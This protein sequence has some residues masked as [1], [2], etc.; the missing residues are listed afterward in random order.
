MT[1]E[2]TDEAKE[3]EEAQAGFAAGYERA[4]G[5][6]APAAPAAP[7]KSDAEKEA[8]AQAEAK[9]LAE[10]EWDGVPNVVR[11][12]LEELGSLPNTVNKLAGHIGGL[13]NATSRI[14]ATLKAAKAATQEA[15]GKAPS[16][17][18][19]KAAISNPA[20]W[21][22]L[23][24]EWDWPEEWSSTIESE[25][26]ALR[27]EIGKKGSVDVESVQKEILSRVGDR[28]GSFSTDLREVIRVDM[29]HPG[30][31]DTVKKDGFVSWSLDGGP[32]KEQYAQ[33][34]EIQETDPA[35]ANE[36]IHGFARNHPEWWALKGAA[37][38]SNRASDAIHLLDGYSEHQKQVTAEDAAR[39]KR[40][41][42][43][44]GAVVPKGTGGPAHT[45]ISDAEAFAR[46]YKRAK[47]LK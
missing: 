18:Q 47:G 38:F 17:E 14:E 5:T 27:E 21:K 15:G 20:A 4:K 3:L 2:L 6:K 10:K 9:A 25:F 16:D 40:E 23:Q 33:M 42:R 45:G 34:K 44:E 35:Q 29:K 1:T 46:G 11:S 24:D 31:E 13:T 30:W 43:L 26:A 19:V 36:M 12:K 39:L 37:I 28:L 32:S 22:K 8:E 7:E 41:K